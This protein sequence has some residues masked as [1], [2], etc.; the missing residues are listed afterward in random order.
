M[1]WLPLTA[2]KVLEKKLSEVK[3]LKDR[4]EAELQE[5]IRKMETE[6]ENANIRASDKSRSKRHTHT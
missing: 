2:N 1:S 4:R 3:G 6:V 5:E